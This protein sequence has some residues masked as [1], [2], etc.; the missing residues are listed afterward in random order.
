MKKQK[1]C[2]I[3]NE[4]TYHLSNNAKQFTNQIVHMKQSTNQIHMPT[5][6]NDN[7]T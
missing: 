3:K 2:S 4:K 6:G 7:I 5:F 1:T